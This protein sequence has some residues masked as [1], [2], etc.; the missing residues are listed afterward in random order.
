MGTGFEMDPSPDTQGIIPRAVIYLFQQMENIKQEFPDSK[1]DFTVQLNFVELYNEEVVDLLG[2]TSA[3]P[4]SAVGGSRPSS[5]N[6]PIRIHEDATGSIY[7]AGVH[8]LT[9]ASAHETLKVLRDGALSRTT[10]STN[11]NDTS[12]RSHAIFTM[13]VIQKRIS[14]ELGVTVGSAFHDL[15]LCLLNSIILEIIITGS[16][17]GNFVCQVSLC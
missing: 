2:Q 5:A 4:S 10:A 3:R 16:R 1:A 6:A 15:T 7:L 9:T 14:T 8:T 12:S 11:M 13:H 17:I